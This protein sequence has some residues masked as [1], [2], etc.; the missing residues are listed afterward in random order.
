LLFIFSLFFFYK[1]R[2]QEGRIGPAL[3]GGI[4]TSEREEVVG[5]G[6]R[7]V[8]MVKIMYTHACKCKK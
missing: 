6:S 7:R 4:D 5:K 1:I 3:G 2:E 8:N